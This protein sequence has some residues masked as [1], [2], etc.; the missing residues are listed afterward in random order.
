MK[1]LRSL[2]ML[3]LMIVAFL[4][5]GTAAKADPLSLTLSSPFQ[6]ANGITG[7]VVTFDATVTN[8]TSATVFLNGDDWSVNSPLTLDDSSYLNDFPLSLGAG[9]S[10]TGELFAVDVPSGTSVGLYPGSFDITGGADDS[11]SDVVGSA[12]FDV[13]VTPEP[14]SLLLLATGLAGLGGTLRRRLVG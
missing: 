3:F 9:D 2:P 6:Y 11:A 5:A 8:L 14:S 10:F 4:L 13:S 12:D 7:S 1:N